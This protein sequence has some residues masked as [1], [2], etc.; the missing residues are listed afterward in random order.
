M[1]FLW[2]KV[3]AHVNSD[4]PLRRAIDNLGVNKW[5]VWRAV[6]REALLDNP[7]ELAANIAK[8]EYQER[9]NRNKLGK[10][11]FEQ[12]YS[13]SG[14][15]YDPNMTEELAE[16]LL[17]RKKQREI[18]AYIISRGKGGFTEAAGSFGSAVLASFASPSNIALSF[19]PIGGQLRWAKI[20]SKYG[21]LA[22][23]ASKAAVSSAAF[24]A[25]LEPAMAYSRHLEQRD[26]GTADSLSNVA[27]SGAF[28]AMVGSL[29]YGANRLR[30][31][32]VDGN[33]QLKKPYITE[34]PVIDGELKAQLEKVL[35]ASHQEQA[36]L[37]LETLEELQQQK[38]ALFK[39]HKAKLPE[40][41]NA[42]Q[43][44]A[45]TERSLHVTYMTGG[46]EQLIPDYLLK[47]LQE[48]RQAVTHLEQQYFDH[49][50]YQA[51]RVAKEAIDSKITARLKYEQSVAKAY[52]L[53]HED[54]YLARQQ[55]EDGKHIDLTAPHEAKSIYE[56]GKG[57]IDIEE[58]GK[59]S[60]TSKASETDKSINFEPF[61]T[62]KAFVSKHKSTEV[63]F[64][65]LLRQAEL[66]QQT[67]ARE[68]LCGLM[69][70]LE[71]HELS[72]FFTS[73]SF[74]AD[75]A[76]E[77]ANLT[78]NSHQ[79]GYTGSKIALQIA[80]II[81]HWQGKAINRA[82]RAGADIKPLE[83]YITRQMH[84]PRALRAMGY[85]QWHSFILPLLDLDKTGDIR[86]FRNSIAEREFAG[87]TERKT[88]A[89]LNV[90]E[91]LSTGST[92]KLPSAVEFGKRS[93]DLKL[94][95]DALATGLHFDQH[96]DYIRG[97]S[98]LAD[99][100]SEARKLHFKTA[101]HW[102]E[103]N[104]KCG[105]YNLAD[106]ILLNLEKLGKATG[107]IEAIGTNP[108]ENFTK[109]KAHFMQELREKAAA[110]DARVLKELEYLRG[111]QA[112]NLFDL[113]RGRSS[114]ENPTLA[115]IGSSMRTLKSMSSLGSMVISSL[116]DMASWVTQLANNGV[117]ILKAYNYLLTDLVK[118]LT[119]KEKRQFASALGIAAESTLGFAY[120]RLN[121]DYPALGHLSKLSNLFFKL[122]CMDWWDSS[123]KSAMGLVLSKVTAEHVRTNF[124]ELPELLQKQLS[125]YDIDSNNWHLYKYLR[126]AVEGNY[127]L[128]PDNDL[129]P[130][131]AAEQQLAR[132]KLP[133]T[134]E[135]ITRIKEEVTNNLRR[136]FLDN[137]DTAIAT[138]H[139]AEQA[140]IFAG[141]KRGTW[142]G[143]FVRFFMQFKTFP[144]SYVLRP[145]EAATFSGLPVVERTGVLS[146]DMWL[147]MQHSGTITNMTHLLMGST[148][149][150]YLAMCARSVLRGQELPDP[151]D[152][153]VWAASVVKGGGLGIFGDFIFNEY[154]RYGRTFLQEAAGPVLADV[155]SVASIVSKAKEGKTKKAE[156]E[157]L[158]LL[159]NN[160]P[161]RNLFYLQPAI[162]L[163]QKP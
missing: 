48:E 119:S 76:R 19:V 102:L 37:P 100:V 153:K 126:Q 71:K 44:A 99:A 130:N 103:Y 35:Q 64:K 101:E 93:I 133:V 63:G 138:P 74:Q 62:A 114:P 106:S 108:Q 21:K 144:I 69:S 28:G 27:I 75:I 40:L 118:S 147:A 112:D 31:K 120:S 66:R 107:M 154:D 78:A 59:A 30:A 131:Y 86:P 91:D 68:L 38:L 55:L 73:K 15:E 16:Y 7:E 163:M 39:E 122:N 94:V 25:G 43:A 88:A 36:T 110:G 155:N 41:F 152:S 83:G 162:S 5:D 85:Q 11:E 53:S 156:E 109:L 160:M 3:E 80:R 124:A 17:A 111:R 22:E 10:E 82:N 115:A 56:E 104:A 87:D 52:N 90:R 146:K 45:Q 58:V 84:A 20:A 33:M 142:L 136:Y 150:G 161:F 95:F 34:N 121:A 135:N 79:Q 4:V 96:S 70:D 117:P 159:L 140:F 139:A 50:A 26:Y 145:L 12:H 9:F 105:Q 77:L 67:I 29:A 32:L 134:E 143:E 137:I 89:Y 42:L 60:E 148:V 98:N 1:S 65:E 151:E 128:L 81:Q 18:N 157:A 61:E 14:L 149:L 123:F 6:G 49:P 141:T 57:K 113:M 46:N 24:Q 116:P 158:K 8:T 2:S 92:H 132:L 51:Y 129:I 72:K 47:I 13:D 125:R 54:S 127:Y 23:V 97:S